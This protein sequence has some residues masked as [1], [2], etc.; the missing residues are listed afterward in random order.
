MLFR[1]SPKPHHDSHA[2]SV[3]YIVA[4]EAVRNVLNVGT[5]THYKQLEESFN[6][7]KEREREIV[8]GINNNPASPRK[9]NPKPPFITALSLKF[10]NENLS[11]VDMCINF[12]VY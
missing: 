10:E 3:P 7:I 8:Q 2:L 6:Q 12:S 11:G 5:H 1:S 4:L 9:N